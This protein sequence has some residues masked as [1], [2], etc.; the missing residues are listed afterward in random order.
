MS[1]K[2]KLF[3]GILLLVVALLAWAWYTP[4]LPR[5]AEDIYIVTTTYIGNYIH[6]GNQTE[7]KNAIRINLE[8]SLIEISYYYKNSKKIEEEWT[9]YRKGTITF[10]TR[11]CTVIDNVLPD[12]TTFSSSML[13]RIV[14]D[15]RLP[16]TVLHSGFGSYIA[17]I[18]GDPIEYTI[19]YT[20]GT[21]DIEGAYVTGSTTIWVDGWVKK[22]I[23]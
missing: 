21:W 11:W 12:C 6:D 17:T 15:S 1:M 9:Y 10:Y 16:F 4:P 23:D 3:F 5:A 2:K 20:K 7:I 14:I 8:N 18:S 13:T 19:Y 22:P